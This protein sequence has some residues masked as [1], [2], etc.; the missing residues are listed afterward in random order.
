MAQLNTKPAF[1][2]PRSMPLT[3]LTWF[4][5]ILVDRH[6]SRY[7]DG[8][9]IAFPMPP[10]FRSP[11][12]CGPEPYEEY[13]SIP[14]SR[15][16]P[17]LND[18]RRRRSTKE[19]IKRFESMSVDNS[20]KAL[21]AHGTR[22]TPARTHRAEV[23]LF[24]PHTQV[25]KKTSPLR[26]SF[27]NLLSVFKKGKRFGK[28]KVEPYSIRTRLGHLFLTK[29]CP[30]FLPG[31]SMSPICLLPTA[32]VWDPGSALLR[33]IPCTRPTDIRVV[34]ILPVW[35]PCDAVLHQSHILLTSATTQGIRRTDVVS[36]RACTDVKSLTSGDIGAEQRAL[37]PAMENSAIP[38]VFELVF[39][40]KEKQRF[41]VP[42][43]K[44][45]A[46]WVSAIC[47]PVPDPENKGLTPAETN[48]P[49][50][51]VASLQ[52]IGDSSVHSVNTA[53]SSSPR[54]EPR[55][56]SF[57]GGHR[58]QR[59]PVDARKKDL[60]PAPSTSPRPL[61]VR[62]RLAEM[63][64][65]S[66]SGTSPVRV[67]R[68]PALHRA[69]QFIAHGRPAGNSESERV[70]EMAESG[71][72]VN[73]VEMPVTGEQLASPEPSQVSPLGDSDS[74][75]LTSPVSAT[76]DHATL[77]SRPKSVFRLREEM[78]ARGSTLAQRRASG[79][80]SSPT[81]TTSHVGSQMGETVDALL[82]VMD[83]HAERQLIKTAELGDQLEIV[84]N[85]VRNVAAN[86]RVA[87]LGRDEDSRHLAEIHTAVDDVRSAL[88]HLD[89]RQQ[90]GSSTAI[91]QAVDERLRS[92]QAE[93]FLALE[94]IQALLKSS[95]P[96]GTVDGGA[97]PGPMTGEELSDSLPESRSSERQHID[98]ADIRQK[99]NMLVELSVSRPVPLQGLRLDAS[100][101]STP[102]K[103]VEH[104]EHVAKPEVGQAYKSTMRNLEESTGDALTQNHNDDLHHDED[105]RAQL[106][107]QQAESVRYLNEL[108]TWLETFVNGGTAQI[109]AIA[110][111]VQ[112]LC[113]TLGNID[114]LHGDLEGPG[115]ADADA[116]AGHM[117]T[118]TFTLLQGIR[119][120]AEESKQRDR[121]SAHLLGTVNGLVAALNEDMRKNAE[122][123]NTYSTESVLGVIERQRQDQERM[124]RTLA[125]ELSDDIRG[126]RLRFV[127]AMKEATAINVQIH[128]EEFKKELTREVLISTQEVGRLQRE[129]QLLEQQIADL[130]SFY[131]K[132]KQTVT[133]RSA[134]AS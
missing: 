78:R 111:D 73:N 120:L 56:A 91:T 31:P 92:N 124:L 58:N 68:R 116:G 119:R 102:R 13:F 42:T 40:G 44:D 50:G 110:E 132:Q 2:G 84:Q 16:N 45:R 133:I 39:D 108:N 104:S 57:G 46:A 113:K 25:E 18:A 11:Q 3:T 80:S 26:Q 28:E 51:G 81:S 109:M 97:K 117:E 95:T 76:S 93:I 70:P 60:E 71:G 118:R 128:V 79:R 90:D 69:S 12:E 15:Q 122:M 29:I 106:M 114:E 27:R 23:G 54:N 53:V 64:H 107:E 19:L 100:Q 30:N 74:G 129:R 1:M 66:T 125:N 43:V 126:E 6:G 103:H 47:S 61:S 20:P 36:L 83:V 130:F 7:E 5:Y 134:L 55:R 62:K 121:D 123:R 41:A 8:D 67:S 21:P 4:G 75:R 35:I 127:E 52:R 48:S 87:I 33:P 89:T 17:V 34:S 14:L 88:A 96:N 37:L 10:E 72:L 112:K 65:D 94:E 131:S 105:T 86:V 82:D 101:D 115:D 49:V 24:T 63:Q 38:K 98:L 99:L 77:S 85:D 32:V 9:Q 22:G 59:D